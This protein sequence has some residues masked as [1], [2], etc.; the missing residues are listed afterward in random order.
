MTACLS[1]AWASLCV[2]QTP[3]AGG[4]NQESIVAADLVPP[5][6]PNAAVLAV[7][8]LGEQVLAGHYKVAI[9]RMN[10]QWKE[11]TAARMKGMKNLERQLEETVAQMSRLGIAMVSFKP[12]GQPRVYQVTPGYREINKQGKKQQAFLYTKWLVFV[13]TVT[14]FRV[15]REGMPKASIVESQS[16]QVAVA[17][18]GKND[19]TFIDG[20]GLNIAD[21]R[22]LYGTLPADLELPPILKREIR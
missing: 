4:G 9:D 5:E 18:K 11:R 12:M 15:A 6:V 20:S 22:G 17:E 19:W 1:L 21:L 2:A 3:E 8:Q 14:T 13:P 10:P 7:Q 16:Y